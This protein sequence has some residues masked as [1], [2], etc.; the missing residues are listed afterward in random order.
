MRPPADHQS[1]FDSEDDGEDG[2]DR[3]HDDPRTASAR[4]FSDT[5][6]EGLEGGSLA[7]ERLASGTGQFDLRAQ[8][9]AR[10]AAHVAA[11]AETPVSRVMARK[12]LCVRPEM[13]VAEARARMLDRGVSGLPVVD[14]WGRAVGMISKTDLVEQEVTSER[15]ARRV[16]DVMTPMV[17]A[18]PPDATI[19]QAAALM[20][21]EGIHRLVILDRSGCVVGVVSALDVARWL[22]WA[23]GHPVGRDP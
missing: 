17:F 7:P 23:A 10:P 16:A 6:D 3:G 1:L 19:G 9:L 5:L 12:V 11:S 22:G 4:G 15:G 18:L 8:T 13:D 21:Y 20:A 14:H 2:F